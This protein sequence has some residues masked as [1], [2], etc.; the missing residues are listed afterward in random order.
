MV[1]RALINVSFALLVLFMTGSSQRAA[2][3]DEGTQA[4]PAATPADPCK[5]QHY[6]NVELRQCYTREQEK[7]TLEVKELVGEIASDFRKDDPILGPVIA[8]EL[9]KAAKAVEVSQNSWAIYRKR[10]C[11]AIE[12]SYTTG[13]GAGTAHEECMYRL[14]R[15]RIAE[16]KTDFSH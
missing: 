1:A 15:Q 9:H 8:G 16:L 7:A 3:P 6:C 4:D 10:H 5:S 12:F 11:E 14:A 13:S 2:K